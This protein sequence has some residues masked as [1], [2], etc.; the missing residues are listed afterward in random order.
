MGLTQAE[1]LA[2]D[3]QVS[4]LVEQGSKDFLVAVHVDAVAHTLKLLLVLRFGLFE[5]LQLDQ[6]IRILQVSKG[7]G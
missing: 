1:V 6:Q 7:E 5:G 2:L 4:H 3:S